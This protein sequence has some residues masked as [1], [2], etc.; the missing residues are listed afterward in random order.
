MHSAGDHTEGMLP[1][2]LVELIVM[3]AV[4]HIGNQLRRRLGQPGVVEEIIAGVL[5]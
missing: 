1:N 3:I 2:I 5:L 4:A